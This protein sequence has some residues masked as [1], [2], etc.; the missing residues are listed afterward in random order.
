M[1]TATFKTGVTERFILLAETL[2]RS[3]TAKN[4]TSI[5]K[6]MDQPLQV[7][8]KLMNGDRIVTLEQASALSKNAK[9][10]A[11]W[12]LTGVGEMFRKQEIATVESADDILL[13][14]SRAVSNFEL[15]GPL[16]EKLVVAFTDLKKENGALKDEVSSLKE[17]I[18]RML[19]AIAENT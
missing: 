9:V 18:I 4:Y 2:M 13:E 3:G 10:N 12:L 8:S 16:A 19:E 11:D 17:K 15:Q 6:L 5:A 7:V 14:I 1:A